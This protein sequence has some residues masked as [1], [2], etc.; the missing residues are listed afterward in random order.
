MMPNPS[1]GPLSERELFIT[2]TFN[3]PRELVWK[4]FTEPQ[5]MMRWWGPKGFTT[6]VCEIDLR[7]GGV[8]LYVMRAPDGGEFSVQ[9]IYHEIVAPERLVY[10]PVSA[11]P[12]APQPIHTVTFEEQNGKTKVSLHSQFPSSAERDE[13]IRRGFVQGV[14]EGMDAL[15]AYLETL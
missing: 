14:N 9:Q 1:A 4:M 11:D 10:G 7:P 12:E 13:T 6:P 15:E 5:H 3:A 2:R 8:W